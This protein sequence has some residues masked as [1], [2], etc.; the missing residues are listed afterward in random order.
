MPDRKKPEVNYQRC[1][2]RGREIVES[3]AQ[4]SPEFGDARAEHTTIAGDVIGDVLTYA[5]SLPRE[6]VPTVYG[7]HDVERFG[8]VA[9]RGVFDVLAQRSN[10]VSEDGKDPDPEDVWAVIAALTAYLDPS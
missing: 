7:L 3:Y 8:T 2:D 6:E 5:A 1:I 4:Q 10:F 9:G